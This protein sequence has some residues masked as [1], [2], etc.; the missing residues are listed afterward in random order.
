MT[1]TR[2]LVV[3]QDLRRIV[4]APLPWG[5]LRGKTVLV[6]GAGGF[7]PAYMVETLLYL[8]EVDPTLGVRVIGLVRNESR[9]R[10]RFAHY[11]GRHDLSFLVQDACEP[12][13]ID[14]RVDMV[15]H[16]ASNASP[17]FYGSH[18][19]ETLLPNTV[20]THHLLEF[21]R[22]TGVERFLFFSSGEVYGE[23]ETAQVP[24]AEG[25][26]GVVDPASLRSC[27]AES[28][29]MG[30]TMCVAWSHEYGVDAR[31]V[32]PFHT[33][34]P[35][36]R[37][38]DG[39]VFADFVADMV[40]GR[41]IVMRSDGTARRAFCYIA[42]ATE[43]FFTVLLKGESAVPYN[44]G[45]EDA[46]VSIG[47]LADILVR[48]AP[49]KGLRVVREARSGEGYIASTISRNAPDTSRLRALGWTP[50]TTIADGFSRTVDSFV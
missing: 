50:A 29:R 48:I 5:L 43:G 36:M 41:D 39:R 47:E 31:I 30:E 11:E 44:V 26:Y 8:N 7:L 37:L 15:I 46:E 4:S 9:A 22:R 32:R 16:A 13:A 19:V 40:S 34:G 1:N 12:L 27:Y 24:T 3:E 2:H 21:C 35:G 10:A 38:D 45:N 6:T 28:K 42:D 14:E 20:G 18:P 25:V 17:K 33:Y 23:V 49:N